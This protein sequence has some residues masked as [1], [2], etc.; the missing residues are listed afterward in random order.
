MDQR[1]FWYLL[2]GVAVDSFFES[3]EEVIHSLDLLV[4]LGPEFAEDEGFGLVS[5]GG[6]DG[7]VGGGFCL[8]EFRFAVG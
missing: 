7:S 6:V 3:V 5:T 1:W 4:A 8:L 2:S